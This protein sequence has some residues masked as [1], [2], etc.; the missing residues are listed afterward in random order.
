MT[1]TTILLADDHRVVIEGIKSALRDIPG[2]KVIGE[3]TDGWEALKIADTLRPD[4]MVLDISMPGLS[5]IEVVKKIKQTALNIKIIIY[6]MHSSSEFVIDL[7]KA[8]VSGYVLKED[9]V[10]DL[11]LTL[12]A[13]TTG[14]TYASKMVSNLL[15]KY[16]KE[17]IDDPYNSLSLREQEIFKN[18]AEGKSIKEIADRLFIS[19]KTVESHKYNVMQKLGVKSLT[20]LTKIAIKKNLINI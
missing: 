10:S 16:V 13:V 7:F 4:I 20:E 1:E 9:P 8:G 3:A 17:P 2:F 19:P 18:L 12:K 11:I 5:G 14:E 15:L 6:T